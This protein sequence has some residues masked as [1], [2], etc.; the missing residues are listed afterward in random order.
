MKK[1]VVIVFIILCTFFVACKYDDDGSYIS[2]EIQ[3]AIVFE[4][5]L[6][7]VVGDTIF[8]ELSFSR[9]L[10]EQGFPN[11]LDVYESSGADSFFYDFDLNKFSEQ[12]GGFRRIDIADNLIFSEKGTVTGFGGVSADLDD[13]RANYESR[14]GIILAE[15]GRFQLDLNFYSLRSSAYSED[16][17]QIDIQHRF[18]GNQPDFEF[19]V[20]E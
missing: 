13:E 1:I 19:T 17:V 5:N 4:N 2:L 20:T 11:K 6:N 18:T 8:F 10:D 9:Y 15:T 16:R 12:A 7:Y 3:D 14:V